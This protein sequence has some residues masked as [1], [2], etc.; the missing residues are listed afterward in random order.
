M[1]KPVAIRHRFCSVI[2]KERAFRRV[3]NVIE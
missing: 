1:I 2:N 3:E